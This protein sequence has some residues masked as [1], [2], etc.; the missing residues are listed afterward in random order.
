[1]T[2]K[3]EKA[4]LF[5]FLKRGKKEE[6]KSVSG[7]EEKDHLSME[8][9]SR[10]FHLAPQLMAIINRHS[11]AF[12]DVNDAF[13][14]TLGYSNKEIIGLT[15]NDIQIF[16]DIE[17]SNR[18]LRLL[19]KFS[20]VSDFPVNLKMKNG[21]ERPFLFSAETIFQGDE[22]F[23]LTTYNA[24]SSL[25]DKTI[26]TRTETILNEIFETVSS[27]LILIRISIDNKFYIRDINSKVE[28]VESVTR[29]DVIEKCVSD[30]PLAKR[31]KLME[32]LNHIRITGEPHKL[33][34]SASGDD[35][36]GYYMGFLLSNRDIIITW[37]ARKGDYGKTPVFNSSE[38][39]FKKM[40]NMLPEMIY[41]VDLE[42]KIIYANTEGLRY[43]GYGEEDLKNGM[44]LA[45]IFPPAELKRA[46][47][48]LKSI[49]FTNQN[50]LNEYVAKKKN[51]ALVPIITHT[52][53]I[54]SGE[55]VI[56]YRGVVTDI[57]EQKK[58]EE[59]IVREKAFLEHLI[60]STPEAIVI[61][62][63]PGKITLI[64][65]E[66]TNLFGYTN[67]EALGKY[68]DDLVVPDELKE[69]A[70]KIDEMA[71]TDRKAMI[72]T[73][74]KD[75]YGTMIHVNLIASSIVISDVTVALLGIYRDITSERKAQLIQDILYNISTTALKQLDIK[76]IYP[77]IVEE[78]NKIWDTNNFYIVLY[79]RETKVLSL[80]FFSDEKDDFNEIPAKGTI[81][82]WVIN[83]N[84]SV[85]LSE[86]DMKK[87]EDSGEIDLVGTPCKVWLGVPL[88][89]DNDIIGVMC[90]QDYNSPDKFTQDDLNMLE[91]IANQ[92][93]V[94]IQKRTM[95]DNLIIARQK[96]EEAA[97]AKQ[98]FMSTMSHEIRTPLNEV[99][100]ISNLLM[101]TNP[102]DDQVDLIKTLRFSAN[103][104]MTLVNDV[105][106]YNKMESGKIVFEQTQFNLT[107][108]LD[109]M[110]RS[111]SFRANEKK[112]EF[113]IIKDDKVPSEVTGDQIRLNQILSNLLSNALKF[114][115]KGSINVRI[116]ELER[117]NHQS[118]IQFT[119][120][121]TGIGIPEDKHAEIFDSFTQASADTTRRFGGT[122]LGLAICKKL[123]E[124]QGGTISVESVPDKGSSFTFNLLFGV[125]SQLKAKSTDGRAETFKALEG[126]KI[127]VAEDNKINFFVASRFLTGWGVNVSHAENGQLA[128][129]M[130]AKEDFD[131]IL[132]DLHMPILDGIEASRI[133]R[134]STNPRIRNIPIIALTAAIMSESH[135][136]IEDLNINDYVLKP[137]KPQD[138]YDR[139][140]KHIR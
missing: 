17:D 30:T 19:S 27:Y 31:A 20:K 52:F 111:Y 34:G 26:R 112:L 35:S 116:E 105:L 117:I 114:T 136:R 118:R 43:F 49:S 83:H 76:D 109:E 54:F 91:F 29:A 23:L 72:Q 57:S 47:I 120:I 115:L 123:V 85:L 97:Q 22:L 65:K 1:M 73:M 108:F 71:N 64:N 37:E 102:N 119:V 36:E 98:L 2:G 55:K 32:L 60:D 56:G 103:H 16:A 99:I 50:V 12:V 110:K 121:D 87:M 138:L 129:E 6:A 51:G 94:A 128:L 33:S 44:T 92:I 45:G 41:E 66:F 42:G 135:D 125:P 13:L 133:I 39:V 59:Q 139:I 101:Q 95:L 38:H 130:I 80:P 82:G 7:T 74:R 61:T 104:L 96:A 11:G 3:G 131:L 78:L 69:E 84:K 62:D 124:L 88:R 89:V 4:D 53:G 63:I 132:M 86:E 75:K 100:G 25:T 21:D 9:A 81:T 122:G 126:K 58:N 40:A 79:D 70:E 93:A 113:N 134:N 28:D 68:I 140:L 18:Y 48:T 77:T 106:D 127:L 5:R 10:A 46:I 107:D 90:L 14:S 24:I 67:E 8:V 15:P 137:F